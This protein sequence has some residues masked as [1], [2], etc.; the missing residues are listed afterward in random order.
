M[1]PVCAV[2]SSVEE[3]GRGLEQLLHTESS[4]ESYS[5]SYFISFLSIIYDW[6]KASIKRSPSSSHSSEAKHETGKCS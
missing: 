1:P 4:V 6:C 3:V 5:S 2:R